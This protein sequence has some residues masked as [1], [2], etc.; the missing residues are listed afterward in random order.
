MVL[1][2]VSF[3]CVFTFLVKGTP[4]KIIKPRHGP[5]YFESEGTGTN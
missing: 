2:V 3:L 5:S 1:S 4:P